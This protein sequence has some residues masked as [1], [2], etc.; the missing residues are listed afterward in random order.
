MCPGDVTFL[1]LLL[2]HRHSSLRLDSMSSS[3]FHYTASLVGSDGRTTVALQS[4]ILSLIED[5]MTKRSSDRL[6]R[7]QQSV[8]QPLSTTEEAI[9]VETAIRLETFESRRLV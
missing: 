4:T 3:T 1:F 5:S 6:T 8:A 2:L 7:V 9:R